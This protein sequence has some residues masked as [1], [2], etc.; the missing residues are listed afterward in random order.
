MLKTLF[1]ASPFTPHGYCLLWQP[2][3]VALS[4]GSDLLI[5]AS[6]FF[7]AGYITYFLLK[8]RQ[9]EHKFLLGLTALYIAACGL[10]HLLGAVIIWI[11][12][13]YIQ[14]AIMAV[15]A[16]ISAYT[17]FFYLGPRLSYLLNFPT[18]DELQ[19]EIDARKKQEAALLDAK[20][21][22][23]QL[24]ASLE[25]RV[26][27]E[28]EKNL[29]KERL[30]IQQSRL[31]AMGEMIGNIAHQWRQPLNALGLVLANIE[32]ADHMQ[33]LN[34]EYLQDLVRTGEGLIQQMSSTIDDFRHFFRPQKQPEPFSAVAAIE[35]TLTLVS[36]GF[37][38]HQIELR[39]EMGEDIQILG[40]ANEFSQVL[41]NLLG[42]AKD[43]VL[44]QRKQGGVVVI[45][46]VRDESHAIVTVADNGGGIPAAVME[47]IFEPY[48]S[49]KAQGT[50]IGLYMSKMIIENSMGGSIIAHN[51]DG[52]AEFTLTCPIYRTDAGRDL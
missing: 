47:Q 23:R 40:F 11:P 30:L 9:S 37:V 18:A 25:Q 17:A 13:Y 20:E 39:R 10:T 41:L 24:N 26:L 33:Q 48:F 51:V 15:T 46:L 45:R 5:A 16:A 14:A 1:E 8:R 4:V 21:V 27:E 43:A 36:P 29:Q 49:T 28:T 31:A 32:D 6:Y 35:E 19:R 3:L 52:G 42:N 12:L 22:L 2:G 34:P 7:I 44:I 50:G 38:N